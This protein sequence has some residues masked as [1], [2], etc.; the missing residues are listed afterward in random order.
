VVDSSGTRVELDAEPI[1]RPR[2]NLT[3]YRTAGPVRFRSVAF[4]VH[5]DGWADSIV[6]F[7]AFSR[8][9]ASGAYR[10][11]LSLPSGR[12]ARQVRLEAGPVE[13]R[14]ELAA[15]PSKTVTVPVSGY[16]LPQLSI[17]VDRADF[18]GAETTRPRLVAARVTALEFIPKAGS[19]N[20]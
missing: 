1:A 12:L 6:R 19:R 13:R 7:A 5:H 10:V 4:G 16:P 11:V 20:Q 9:A 17:T 15:G 18:V 8:G 3:L 14:I 2:P